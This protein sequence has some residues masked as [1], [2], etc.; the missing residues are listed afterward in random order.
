[1]MKLLFVINLIALALW[2]FVL[3]VSPDL[4]ALGFVIFLSLTAVFTGVLAFFDLNLMG[5]KEL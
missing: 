5:V 3:S 4:E 2:A 1:M